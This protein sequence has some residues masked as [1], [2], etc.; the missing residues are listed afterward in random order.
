MP[1]VR[2]PALFWAWFPILFTLGLLVWQLRFGGGGPPHVPI[3]FGIAAAAL[4]G[5][6]HGHRWSALEHAMAQAVASAVPV[7]AIMLTVGM[8]IGTWLLCGTVPWLTVT[9]LALLDPA[10]FLPVTC[11]TCAV[12]SL[13]VGT[14]WGTV[15]TAGVIL[16]GIGTALGVSAPLVAGVVISGATFRIP[17]IER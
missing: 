6:T 10:V 16:M 5:V 2:T 8:I 4:V 14:S 15:G 9:A 17:A 11:V 13:L 3:V 1:A 7:M 12:V